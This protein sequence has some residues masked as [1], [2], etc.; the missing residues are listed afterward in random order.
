MTEYL[1]LQSQPCTW[2]L[3]RSPARTLGMSPVVMTVLKACWVGFAPE[4]WRMMVTIV[5]VELSRRDMS[6]TC[7]RESNQIGTIGWVNDVSPTPVVRL[8]HMTFG[9]TKR[10]KIFNIIT[11]TI[12]WTNQKTDCFVYRWV[13]A[14]TMFDLTCFPA[15]VGASKSFQ[16]LY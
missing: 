12:I 11:H 10:R 4:N 2:F 1:G 13:R 5:S 3:C 15:F 9:Q 16:A 7:R 14:H 6:S 8:Y